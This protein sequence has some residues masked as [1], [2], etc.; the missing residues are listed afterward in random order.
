MKNRVLA[1]ARILLICTL[2]TLA[3]LWVAATT[4]DGTLSPWRPNMVDLDVYRRVGGLVIG[5]SGDIYDANSGLPFL[6]PPF[7]AVLAAGLA[8]VPAILMQVGWVALNVGCLLSILYRCGVR[9]WVL[10]LS[11]AAVIVAVEPVRMTFAFGQLGIV[12]VALVALDVLPGRHFLSTR[13]E[14]A[15]PNNQPRRGLLPAGVLSGLAAAIKLTPGITLPYLWFAGRRRAALGVGAGFLAATALGVLI[16]PSESRTFWGRLAQGDTGL[17]G[18][19]VYLTNQSVMGA[20]LRILRLGPGSELL[21]LALAAIVAA[22]GV[23]AGARWHR[24]GFAALGVCLSGVAGLL[25]SP[26][27]WSHHFVWIVP[28]GLLLARPG[29]PVP[30][31]VLGYTFVGWA[32]LAPFKELPSGGDVELTYTL[33]QIALSSVTPALGV[34]LLIVCLVWTPRP[35]AG[36]VTTAGREQDQPGEQHHQA[37]APAPK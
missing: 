23:W 32:A 21:G 3:G 29:V 25:A 11:A 7:A 15:G 9:G 4:F 16:L 30:A 20:W 18:S 31:R 19:I 1:V 33:P 13:A 12:L 22:L 35:S 10:S 26:V 27:S 37:D 36:A 6:Y 8:A 5:G 17:G 14:R 24:R 2:P 34:G 28:L